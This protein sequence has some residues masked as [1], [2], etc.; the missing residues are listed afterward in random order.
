MLLLQGYQIITRQCKPR[1]LGRKYLPSNER[2]H[3][4]ASKSLGGTPLLVDN[5]VEQGVLTLTLNRPRQRHA[6]NRVLLNELHTILQEVKQRQQDGDRSIRAILLQSNGPV[7]CAGHDLK[8]LS[9]LSHAEQYDLF[10]MCASVMTLLTTLPQPTICAVQGLATAAG[11]QLAASCDLVVASRSRASFCTPGAATLGFFCHSPAVPL[12]QSIGYKRSLDMLYTGRL[13]SAN[14]AYQWGLVTRLVDDDDHV[15]EHETEGTDI[16]SNSFSLIHSTS[17]A[18]AKEIAGHSAP[19][20]QAGKQTVQLLHEAPTLETAYQHAS[21][22]MVDNLQHGDA[23][24]G[25]R[26]FIQKKKVPEWNHE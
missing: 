10:Q 11:C 1:A 6:L 25:I 13:V 19:A 20:I 2:L 16:D 22:A 5:D 3:F 15:Q 18:L 23:Q 8:E 14:E 26:C 17:L 24:E 7:F 12:V 21:Q 4:Y 9:T